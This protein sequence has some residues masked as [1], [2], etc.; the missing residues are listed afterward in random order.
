MS[1]PA[2]APPTIAS[3]PLPDPAAYPGEP[4]EYAMALMQRK[5]DI[6]KAIV[7]CLAEKPPEKGLI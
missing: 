4:R 1:I 2:P 5:G 6:E 7:S 3:L